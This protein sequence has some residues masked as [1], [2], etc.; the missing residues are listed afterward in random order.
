MKL[1]TSSP[2]E[3]TKIS[4]DYRDHIEREVVQVTLEGNSSDSRSRVVRTVLSDKER[5]SLTSPVETH[6]G[7]E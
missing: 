3:T 4:S 2:S 5:E 1:P 7:G 6:G